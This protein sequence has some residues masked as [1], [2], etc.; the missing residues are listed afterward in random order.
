LKIGDK[1]I[2][3]HLTG[4]DDN[5]HS[6]S[7]YSTKYVAVIFCCNHCPVC[8]YVIDWEDRMVRI[9]ADYEGKGL[10]L[11]AI[12]V[13]DASEYPDD[14]FQ[15]MKNRARENRFNFP[16]LRDEDQEVARIYGAQR[17]PEVFLFD[18]SRVLRYHGAID[19]NYRD[20]NAVKISYL[21]NA[22]DALVEVRDIQTPDTAPVGCYI[23]WK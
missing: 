9:Q 20:P 18:A 23:K 2:D 8:P 1:A 5:S 16:Y 22:L 17:T 21:R 6:L 4:T 7:D 15:N 11:I 14:S 12:N 3:F 13:N 10:Q 19:D